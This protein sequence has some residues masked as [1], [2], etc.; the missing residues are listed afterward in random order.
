MPM[1]IPP[2]GRAPNSFWTPARD[3]RMQALQL[4]GKS[5]AEIAEILGCSRNAV[6]GRSLR[7]R[8]IQYE[9]SVRSWKRANAERSAEA[10]KRM[11]LRAEKRRK[12]VRAMMKW[13]AQGMP[14]GKAMGRAHDAGAT[15]K[16]I[17]DYFDCSQQAAYERAKAWR[18][19]AR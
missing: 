3:K 8:G 2:R 19:R 10:H 1:G 15:W 13:V 5:A 14:A 11:K 17:G 6:I 16:Q 7:L 4:K 18:E 9:S 12:A